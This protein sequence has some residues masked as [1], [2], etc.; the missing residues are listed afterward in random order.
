MKGPERRTKRATVRESAD[1]RPEYDFSNGRR[2]EYAARYAEGT[3]AV[4]LD[5]DVRLVF[6]DSRAVNEALRTLI[7][8]TGK[9][10]RPKQQRPR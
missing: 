4:L 8:A 1:M 6:T 3:N 9:A 7:R 10:R 2:G 5:A